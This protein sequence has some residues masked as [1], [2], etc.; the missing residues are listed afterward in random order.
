MIFTM[1]G[2]YEDLASSATLDRFILEDLPL[3]ELRD[4]RVEKPVVRERAAGLHIP[5]EL[6]GLVREPLESSNTTIGAA[7]F[8]HGRSKEI[9]F[10]SMNDLSGDRG[11]GGEG[12]GRYPFLGLLLVVLDYPELVLVKHVPTL[13]VGA[14]EHRPLT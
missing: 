9:R 3:E 2:I 7:G 5:D 6:G 14:L 4:E 12:G 11:G 8:I 1:H 13:L 10:H